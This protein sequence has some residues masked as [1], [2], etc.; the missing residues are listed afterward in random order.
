MAAYLDTGVL[1]KLYCLEADSAKAVAATSR[2]GLPWIYCM[3]QLIELRNAVRLKVFRNEMRPEQVN[4]S[5]QRLDDD[6]R[7]GVLAS[8]SLDISRVHALAEDLSARWT[9][10]IGCRTLDILH[11]AAALACQAED[12]ISFDASQIALAQKA[13]LRVHGA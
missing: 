4:L 10:S 6:L 12:F 3:W 8:I 7:A 11:V 2:V 9:A 13:G 1:V 5:L